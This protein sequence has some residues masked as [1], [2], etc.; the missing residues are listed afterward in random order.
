MST[1]E[2]SYKMVYSFC[3][4]VW[5]RLDAKK[6]IHQFQRHNQ[7]F[8]LQ[9]QNFSLGIL[10]C[11]YMYIYIFSLVI[12]NLIKFTGAEAYGMS[13][14]GQQSGQRHYTNF[15]CTG[16]ETSLD[17]CT[18]EAAID[19]NCNFAQLASVQCFAQSLCETTLGNT[20]CCSSSCN[21]GGCFCDEACHGFG[22]CCDNIDNTCPGK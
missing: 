1:P 22:D 3:F 19:S 2:Y 4:S 14:Y 5:E 16:S 18:K 10:F 9:S 7:I 8:F 15:Q 20:E 13:F 12:F 17:S 11:V 6:P 21:A